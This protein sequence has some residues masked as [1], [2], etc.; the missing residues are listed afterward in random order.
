MAG[1]GRPRK[2]A[3]LQHPRR[4]R[5]QELLTRLMSE[6]KGVENGHPG[7]DKD[8]PEDTK[9]KGYDRR[10]IQV[11]VVS[12]RPEQSPPAPDTADWQDAE[13]L[14]DVPADSAPQTYYCLSCDFPLMGSESYCPGCGARLD[15]KLRR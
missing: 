13:N 15:W 5:S 1:R 8:L 4:A 11:S 14:D 12:A 7:S 2:E 6:E 9:G 3:D 10:V